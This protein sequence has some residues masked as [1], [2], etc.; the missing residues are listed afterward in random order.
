MGRARRATRPAEADF[1]RVAAW[2]FGDFIFGCDFDVVSDTGK[3][4]R[5]GYAGAVDSEAMFFRLFD[6]FRRARVIP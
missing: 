5:L 3:L 6:A 4:R 2:P 1:A